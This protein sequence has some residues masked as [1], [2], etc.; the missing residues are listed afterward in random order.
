MLGYD[1]V[2]HFYSKDKLCVH[3]VI[4]GLLQ[5]LIMKVGSE[6]PLELLEIYL[7]ISCSILLL[8]IQTLLAT[9]HKT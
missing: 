5:C 4:V 3:R 2:S 1:F 6:I 8:S 9:I 7:F